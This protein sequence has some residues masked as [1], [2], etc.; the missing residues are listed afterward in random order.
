[1]ILLALWWKVYAPTCRSLRTTNTTTWTNLQ[2]RSPQNLGL[3]DSNLFVQVWAKH[4]GQPAYRKEAK[5]YLPGKTLEEMERHE[6]WH[7]ELLHLQDKKREVDHG[8]KIPLTYLSG[9]WSVTVSNSSC[10]SPRLHY[11]H[12]FFLSLDI[13]NV[14]LWKS[15]VRCSRHVYIWLK[16]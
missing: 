15:S 8:W 12:L 4:R 5:L 10:N 6:D 13:V 16:T 2:G 14:V 7:Q 11:Q 1:M 3:T 9:Q